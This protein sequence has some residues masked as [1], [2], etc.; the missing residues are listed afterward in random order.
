MQLYNYE[1]KLLGVNNYTSFAVCE[2][3]KM[4]DSTITIFVTL[5]HIQIK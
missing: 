5:N 4:A 3:T 2:S 1:R